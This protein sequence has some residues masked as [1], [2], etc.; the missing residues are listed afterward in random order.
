MINMTLGV[1]CRQCGMLHPPLAEGVT[2]PMAKNNP[3]SDIDNI[4]FTFIFQNLKT[5][6]SEKISKDNIVN[7]Q[8]F[9]SNMIL[10]IKK[11]I[12]SYSE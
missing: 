5:L 7:K 4:D 2:C 12:D 11:F 6:S 1:E 10:E 9:F 3:T 8:K